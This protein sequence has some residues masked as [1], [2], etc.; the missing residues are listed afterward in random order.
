M[1]EFKSFN[2][3][4]T[5]TDV[6]TSLPSSAQVLFFMLGMDTEGGITRRPHA[7][8]RMV[9]A[10]ED[11]LQMLIDRHLITDKGDGSIDMTGCVEDVFEEDFN[12]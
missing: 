12:D 1:S 8:T 6:F 3:N 2:K 4:I 9:G 11:D 10:S 7:I 5:E